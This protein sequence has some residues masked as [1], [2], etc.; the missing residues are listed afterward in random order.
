MPDSGQ[1][2]RSSEDMSSPNSPPNPRR[3]HSRFFLKISLPFGFFFIPKKPGRA[4]ADFGRFNVKTVVRSIYNLLSGSELPIAAEDLE[5][6]DLVDPSSP[7]PT[8]FTEEDLAVYASLYEKSGFCTPLQVPCRTLHEELT[9]A[10]VQVPALLI[11]GEKDYYIRSGKVKDYVPDLETTFMPKK[12]ILFRSNFQTRPLSG[13]ILTW[14]PRDMIFVE[15][16]DD[17]RRQCRIPG[18]STRFQ[19]LWTLPAA[20]RSR[21]GIISRTLL[22]VSS[23]FSNFSPFPRFSLL[24]KIL[25]PILL[26]C[27]Q[28]FTQR[29]F[30]E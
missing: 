27:K 2:R 20:S 16:P 12:H 14:V 19:R 10:R 8:W 26:T 1:R 3:P 17:R 25:E 21:E 6:M 9:D 24:G 5:I 18:N 30:Q 13:A 28:F 15:A 7:L 11:M 22:K 29:E 23:P 4:E